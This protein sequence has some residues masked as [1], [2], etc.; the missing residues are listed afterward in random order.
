MQ[1]AGLL[2]MSTTNYGRP[3][4][5]HWDMYDNVSIMRGSH[6][7]KTG[8]TSCTHGF[9]GFR[10]AP[11]AQLGS[12]NFSGFATGLGFSDFLLGIPQ[13]SSWAAEVSPYY[14]SRWY[15]GGLPG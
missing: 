4:D 8:L 12:F 6:A 14:G 13:T 15:L 11:A 7:F 9:P 10:Q 5:H 1:I 2:S 3:V